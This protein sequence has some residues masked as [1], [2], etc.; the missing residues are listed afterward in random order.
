MGDASLLLESC[1]NNAAMVLSRACLAFCLALRMGTSGASPSTI[2]ANSFEVMMSTL[3]CCLYH[4]TTS[5][6]LLGL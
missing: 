6:G 1:G 2:F 4:C 5:W 3:P